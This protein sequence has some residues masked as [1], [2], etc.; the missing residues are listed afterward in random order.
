MNRHIKTKTPSNFN[1]LL[2][3]HTKKFRRENIKINYE[4]F[5]KKIELE[6]T[7]FIKIENGLSTMSSYQLFLMRKN[8]GMDINKMFD[9]FEK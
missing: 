4:I 9:D 6:P 2:G 7:Y 1:E 3:K 8:F 5:A